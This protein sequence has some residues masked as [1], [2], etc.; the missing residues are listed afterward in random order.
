MQELKSSRSVQG[1]YSALMFHAANN[2]RQVIFNG[3]LHM[4][5]FQI[6]YIY[7]SMIKHTAVIFQACFPINMLSACVKWAKMHV[8]GFNQLL[9]RQLSSV[10]PNSDTFKACIDRAKDHASMLAEVGLDFK[11]LVGRGIKGA[12][13]GSKNGAAVAP[14]KR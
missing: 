1:L 13:P 4:Y 10:D 6:S 11:D 7:F 2:H 12:V 5:I 14:T 3:D 8:D 9:D